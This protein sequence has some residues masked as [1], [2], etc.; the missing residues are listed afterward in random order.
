[1]APRPPPSDTKSLFSYHSFALTSPIP[2]EFPKPNNSLLLLSVVVVLAWWFATVW[3]F[4]APNRDAI[5]QLTIFAGNCK[6][7]PRISAIFRCAT[8]LRWNW[9]CFRDNKLLS[10]LYRA[11]LAQYLVKIAKARVEHLI[12]EGLVPR[13]RHLAALSRWQSVRARQLDG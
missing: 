1:M 11:I 5:G 6:Q 8:S 7:L 12:G 9:V 3:D 4:I 10:G 13:G 2:L